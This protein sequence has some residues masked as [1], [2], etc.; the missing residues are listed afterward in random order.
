MSAVAP[1][2]LALLAL[3]DAGNMTPT[4]CD[5]TARDMLI[6]AALDFA[7]SRGWVPA[8]EAHDIG[9][10]HAKLSEG[11]DRA[12]QARIDSLEEVLRSLLGALQWSDGA[13][14]GCRE[15]P[16]ACDLEDAREVARKV[17]R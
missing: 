1:N 8:A 13:C 17:L 3:L 4:S 16:C 11:I 9:I 10:E 2:D 5:G 6:A 12:Y 14:V 7:R 15:R